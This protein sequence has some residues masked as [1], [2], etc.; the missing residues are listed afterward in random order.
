MTEETALT[1]LEQ[2]QTRILQRITD[3]ELRAGL[4]QPYTSPNDDV[5]VTEK[6]LSSILLSN[7]VNYFAFK[8]VGFDF[9]DLS[10]ELRRDA[11]CAPS[12]H[13]LCKSIVMVNTRAPS[14][15]TDCSNRNLSKY[16]I[17]IVQYTARCNMKNVKNFL[18]SLNNGKI[19]RMKFNLLLAPEEVSELLTGYV[20]NGVTCIGMKTDIPIIMDEAILKLDPDF[21]WLGG[22]EIDL[23]LG[24]RTSEFVNYLNPFIVDCSSS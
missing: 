16:Y 20:R 6:R 23:K 21:F 9:Y 10:L 15:V 12:V 4:P 24:I 18:Y 7:G 19:P 13:H 8:Q 22:G 1:E 14:S 2:L 3:L 11:L 5:S 17:I